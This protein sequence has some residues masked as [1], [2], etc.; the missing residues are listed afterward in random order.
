MTDD[1]TQEYVFSF[2]DRE[3]L[4]T[5]HWHFGRRRVVESKDENY[6]GNAL[7]W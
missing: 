2:K 3:I 4:H 7:D 6:E 5:N 1:N